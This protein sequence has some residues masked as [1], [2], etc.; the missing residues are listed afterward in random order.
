MNPHH[1]SRLRAARIVGLLTVAVVL[2]VATG[3]FVVYGLILVVSSPATDNPIAVVI[4]ET[5]SY[6]VLAAVLLAGLV[7]TVVDLVKLAR[8]TRS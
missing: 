4:R 5:P 3:W 6:L 8:R 2:T 7:A 1:G